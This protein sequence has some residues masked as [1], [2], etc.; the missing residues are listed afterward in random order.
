MNSLTFNGVK[1]TITFHDNNWELELQTGNNRA[2][3]CGLISYDTPSLL[4]PLEPLEP[5]NEESQFLQE[6]EHDD[7][8]HTALIK[9]IATDLGFKYAIENPEEHLK[10][11]N[12]YCWNND[13][14]FDTVEQ[15]EQGILHYF[16]IHSKESQDNIEY[17]SNIMEEF[18]KWKM[19][20]S[21]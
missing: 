9:K 2:S 18:K 14:S 10:N 12:A 7:L 21:R 17:N 3:I 19:P 1:A 16:T 5:L 6:I 15:M 13:L 20:T 8:I 4:E 11:F